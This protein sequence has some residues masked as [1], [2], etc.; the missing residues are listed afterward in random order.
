MNET[1][2]VPQEIVS[3]IDKTLII[4]N[5]VIFHWN[6]VLFTDHIFQNV[7]SRKSW[8][9]YLLYNMRLSCSTCP[10]SFWSLKRKPKAWPSDLKSSTKWLN[11]LSEWLKSLTTCFHFTQR[12]AFQSATVKNIRMC[13]LEEFRVTNLRFC[14][15]LF[16]KPVHAF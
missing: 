4:N 3:T 6:M 10:L 7:S 11:S 2:L 8:T 14:M 5:Q 15:Q 9:E 16:R 1:A 13:V 12:T